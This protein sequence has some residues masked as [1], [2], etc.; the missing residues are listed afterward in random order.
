MI[1][2]AHQYS[3]MPLQ[4]NHA[5]LGEA[6]A[7][8]VQNGLL[9]LLAFGLQ[10]PGFAGA[11]PC[12]AARPPPP[13]IPSPRLG[14]SLPPPHPAPGLGSL[15]ELAGGAE[16]PLAGGADDAPGPRPSP[17]SLRLLLHGSPSGPAARRREAARTGNRGADQNPR[18]PPSAVLMDAA[19]KLAEAQHDP[20][21]KAIVVTGAGKNFSAGFDISQFGKAQKKKQ[22]GAAAPAPA[23]PKDGFAD[24]NRMFVALLEAGDKPTVAAVRGPTLGGGLELAMACNARVCDPTAT[25]G[26]PELQLGIIP[27]FGGTQVSGLPRRPAVRPP[28]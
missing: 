28:A 24:T 12:A 20:A 10:V 19:L 11:A 25:L 18:P 6:A 16:R 7:A 15:P 4:L 5:G 17:P 26:L 13:S 1:L 9:P 8:A 27:G 23:I 21:V 14:S 22:P 2:L 3:G